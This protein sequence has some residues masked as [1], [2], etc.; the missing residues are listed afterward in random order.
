M[1]RKDKAG[2]SYVYK[3][4]MGLGSVVILSDISH[5]QILGIWLQLRRSDQRL[6]EVFRSF[7][8]SRLFGHSNHCT[9]VL[10]HHMIGER[11]RSDWFFN[12]KHW[13][14]VATGRLYA[15][16]HH[17][18]WSNLSGVFNEKQMCNYELRKSNENSMTVVL[19]GTRQA[20]CAGVRLNID[21]HWIWTRG[22]IFHR[23]LPMEY[24]PPP[25]GKWTPLPSIPTL[26][27]RHI[28]LIL[29]HIMYIALPNLKHCK[30]KCLP[31]TKKNGPIQ[32][33]IYEVWTPPLSFQYCYSGIWRVIFLWILLADNSA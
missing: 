14:K 12:W 20:N 2:K 30:N 26:I 11:T 15:I 28:T 19:W 1:I 4:G 24:P 18:S 16:L 9:D 22:S 8:G 27:L 31:I 21:P 10:L 3:I 6:G 25:Y 17:L 5:Y 29:L 23:I 13:L 32:K 7:H 33:H